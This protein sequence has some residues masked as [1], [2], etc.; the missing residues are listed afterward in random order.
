M[1]IYLIKEG[2]QLYDHDRSDTYVRNGT[3]Y[4][5]REGDEVLSGYYSRDKINVRVLDIHQLWNFI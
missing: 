2:H 5:S 1:N 4:S 3:K